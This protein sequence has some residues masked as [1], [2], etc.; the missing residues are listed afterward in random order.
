MTNAHGDAQLTKL[1]TALHRLAEESEGVAG[2]HQNGDVATWDELFD[3]EFSSWLG[4][5]VGEAQAH[6]DSKLT[7][8]ALASPGGEGK[9]PCVRCLKPCS[10]E[11]DSGPEC[12]LTD[13]RW[14]CSEACWDA[15]ARMW[16]A[17]TP[18]PPQGEGLREALA[19]LV[20]KCESYMRYHEEKFY[21][22]R[23]MQ[24]GWLGGGGLWPAIKDARA[25]LAQEEKRDE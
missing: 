23:S 18:A 15:A 17:P 9:P 10:T 19:S 22:G 3:G 24:G 21:G 12:Q 5:A 7:D 14:V 20:R 2:L 4:D 8:P 1:L 25:A 16:D 13:G 6:L 11:E